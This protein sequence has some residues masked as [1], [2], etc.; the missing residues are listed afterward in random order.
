MELTLIQFGKKDIFSLKNKETK[1]HQLLS[2]SNK[3][4]SIL[5]EEPQSIDQIRVLRL[6]LALN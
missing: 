5:V 4:S 3:K 6:R 1:Y 2:P